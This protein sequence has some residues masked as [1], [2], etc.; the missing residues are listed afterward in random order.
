MPASNLCPCGS[1]RSYASCCEPYL[2]KAAIAPTAE[3]LM[4]SRYVA[5]CKG[6]VEY[7]ITTRHPSQRKF[8]DRINLI[9]SIKTT[10]WESLTVV[11][12]RQGQRTDTVG[13]VEFLAVYSQP[14][15]GQLHE[16][17]KFIKE[18][19]RW[20]YVDGDLLPPILPKRNQSC[21]CGSGKKFKYCHG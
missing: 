8:D 2:V 4:R 7:L 15:W 12:T 3:A 6:N 18:K 20:F 17:S 19:G 14:E 11:S 9:K 16:R 21:W 10:V 13:Y 5:Y 1:K